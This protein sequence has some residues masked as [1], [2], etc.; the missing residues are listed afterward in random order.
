MK[1]AALYDIHGNLPALEA[2][3]QDIR[4]L[5]VEQIV[6]GGDVL[7][8]PMPYETLN[9]LLELDIPIHF[10]RG[11]G[12]DAVLEQLRGK[13]PDK[14]PEQIREIICWVAEQIPSEYEQIIAAW[15]ETVTIE[16]DMGNVLFC[17]ATPQNNTDIF[18]RLTPEKTLLPV[19]EGLNVSL[20]VC[21]HT[22]MQFDRTI[23]ELRVVNAGSV[24]MP[25]GNAGADWLLLD[26]EV[27][28][29]HTLYDFTNAAELIKGTDYPQAKDFAEN[30]VL[31]P[32][33]EDEAIA[34]F[35]KTQLK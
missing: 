5:A 16:T 20:V 15:P 14:V 7:P 2:V 1:L 22:H 21:G 25:Y 24:G 28:F 10:I 8:G 26:S 19:F 35:S 29:Q 4:R 32:A 6:I 23:G 13:V 30:N 11:N 3:L 31:H 9:Q 17:H 27:Q 12:D 18:T 33:S 34:V